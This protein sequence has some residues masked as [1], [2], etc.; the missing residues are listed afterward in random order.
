M[1]L[2]MPLKMQ[3][4]VVYLPGFDPRGAA[5]YYRSLKGECKT[6]PNTQ[7]S[8][9]V[10]ELEKKS[11]LEG[12][13]TWNLHNGENTTDYFC[14]D[15]QL[16]FSSCWQWSSFTLI[17]KS[18]QTCAGMLRSG[19][20]TQTWQT[21]R[22]MGVTTTYPYVYLFGILFLA[23][24]AL[25]LLALSFAQFFSVSNNA[26]NGAMLLAGATFCAAS[27]G[28]LW[29]YE[30]HFKVFWI[31]RTLWWCR[32]AA[33]E[34]LNKGLERQMHSL[35]Q[36][37]AEKSL[38]NTY[39]EI[40]IVGHS[41]GSVLLVNVLA[42]LDCFSHDRKK[43]FALTLG[44][45]FPLLSFP[46]E[47]HW[48]RNLLF[49]SSHLADHWVNVTSPADGAAYFSCDIWK[50]SLHPETPP[51]LPH[52]VNPRFHTL[53]SKEK[54]K[55]LKRH[56]FDYHFLYLLNGEHTNGYNYLDI[57]CGNISFIK[58]FSLDQV[59]IAK[60]KGFTPPFPDP[61]TSRVSILKRLVRGW[62]SWIHMLFDKSY[63]MK[64]GHVKLPKLNTFVVNEPS[65][66]RLILSEQPQN[67]PKNGLMH[68]ILEPLLGDSIFTTNGAVWER[69]RKMM[70][71]AFEITKLRKVF[72]LMSASVDDM[73]LRFEK[74]SNSRTPL[75]MDI[76]MTHITADIIFRTILGKKLDGDDAHEIFEAFTK[77]QEYALRSML[78]ICYGLPTFW[79]WRKCL[80]SAKRIRVLL[81]A[82]IG[83][84]YNDYFV[85]GEKTK[86][87]DILNALM[88]ARDPDTGLPFS[89]E[90]L[91][92]HV[93]IIF[94]AGHET[95][96]SALTWAFYLLACDQHRQNIVAGE[97]L[98]LVSDR[99]INFS[100]VFKFNF[101]SD[102]FRET[103]RLYP[104]VGFFMREA[105][106][107]FT[108][109]NKNIPQG[110]TVTLSPWLLQRHRSHWENPDTFE[111]ER[112][113]NGCS[114]ESIK[115]AYIPFGKG[116]RVCIGAGFAT[117][118]ALLVMASLLKEFRFDCSTAHTPEPV[119]RVTIRPANGVHLFLRRRTAEEKQSALYA[120]SKQ[121][122]TTPS[123]A[124]EGI[125]PEH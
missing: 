53:Y 18:L 115:N 15:T 61:A 100:D 58:R 81:E 104:P 112:F 43:I 36:F 25:V 106:C 90:E 114:A 76:E 56:K 4:L 120:Y 49:R 30:A 92:D 67:F 26:F 16:N 37:I 59:N 11:Q 101:A 32:E 82:V 29:K 57:C 3:R 123:T 111:P 93:S 102:V 118:E 17:K 122:Q 65:L 86:H 96:A 50:K 10:S 108:M 33:K 74:L 110:A 8:Y 109:R 2:K 63:S 77:Y 66:V 34:G 91:V 70:D 7:Y 80:K 46:R 54:Y 52:K 83:E 22:G 88:E 94:L 72:P 23:A 75:H 113:Q 119:G 117:Q 14:L 28:L 73:L 78:L 124:A 116:P 35:A 64:M 95:S 85:N 24:T 55:K 47:A 62:H 5:F 99:E 39:S 71:A 60:A 1:A 19:L 51:I 107:P 87:A 97:A 42:E 12:F 45:C 13:S 21:S 105:A 9:G 31:L 6:Y 27:S 98:A 38:S 69:Q 40:V 41:I 89:K 84:R 79:H 68:K 48:Y 44:N 121:A 103:L 125:A 20:L